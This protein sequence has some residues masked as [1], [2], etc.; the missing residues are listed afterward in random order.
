MLTPERM[1]EMLKDDEI[2]LLVAHACAGVVATCAEIAN[3]N[4]GFLQ[5]GDMI[6]KHFGMPPKEKK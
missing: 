5:I 6:I 4:R 3:A 1:Q 2:H